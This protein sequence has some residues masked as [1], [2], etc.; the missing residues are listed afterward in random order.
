[1]A[2]MTYAERGSSRAY[3]NVAYNGIPTVEDA[4]LIALQLA[5]HTSGMA[6]I[7]DEQLPFA[8]SRR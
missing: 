6:G 8:C 1:M 3:L 7:P 2:E 4:K 5:D